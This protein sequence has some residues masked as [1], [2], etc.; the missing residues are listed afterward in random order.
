MKKLR[1]YTDI[2]FGTPNVPFVNFLLNRIP[3][4]KVYTIDT[5]VSFFIRMSM[6][7]FSM[8]GPI[9]FSCMCVLERSFW[10]D[11]P[12]KMSLKTTKKDIFVYVIVFM[13][14]FFTL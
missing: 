14:F 13:L 5:I 4:E 1:S 11:N 2:N 9:L 7:N 8:G 12:V 6:T 10:T 3:T